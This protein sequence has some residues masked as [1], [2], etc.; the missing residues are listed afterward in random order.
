MLFYLPV[1]PFLRSLFPQ[2]TTGTT[3]TDTA[4]PDTMNEGTATVV[5]IETGIGI[6]TRGATGTEDTTGIVIDG[7]TTGGLEDTTEVGDT[8]GNARIDLA[9]SATTRC[10][11]TLLQRV[12]VVTAATAIEDGARNVE[13]MVWVLQNEGVLP[14]PMRPRWQ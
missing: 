14:Q 9:Q 7:T 4:H 5:V 8:G 12:I 3:K 2:I 11:L 10:K 13:R 1:Y 6:A